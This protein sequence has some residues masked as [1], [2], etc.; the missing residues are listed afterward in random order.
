[1]EER[2][3]VGEPVPIKNAQPLLEELADIAEDLNSASDVYTDRLR[4]IEEKLQTFNLGLTVQLDTPFL[5]SGW[6]S[7]GEG[8]EGMDSE[9]YE[10][11]RLSFGKYG[12]WCFLVSTYHV[13]KDPQEPKGTP[14]WVLQGEKP[15]LECSRDIRMAAAE[16]IEPLL[17]EVKR[18]A[19]AKYKALKKAIG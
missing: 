16:H 17:K 13:V 8:Q 19:K 11:Y 10:A 9:Y 7:R 14:R 12:R 5:T 15:L 3:V 18:Q 2:M 4:S 1:M 6:H